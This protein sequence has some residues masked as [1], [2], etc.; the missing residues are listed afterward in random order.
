VHSVADTQVCSNIAV[1]DRPPCRA[2]VHAKLT[3][4]RSSTYSLAAALLWLRHEYARS[5]RWWGEGKGK[6]THA[7]CTLTE[8]YSSPTD[9]R[10]TSSMICAS[11]TRLIPFSGRADRR[12][13]V[14][15]QPRNVKFLSLCQSSSWGA[16]RRWAWV[17]SWHIYFTVK[18][19]SQLLNMKLCRTQRCPASCE[20]DK[21]YLSLPVIE[22]RFSSRRLCSLDT[23]SDSASNQRPVEQKSE[24]LPTK[25]T[26]PAT[27]D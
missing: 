10:P 19:R 9:I 8:D 1:F 16:Q 17:A 18:K 3:P 12:I 20:E 23:F 14:F 4:A 5:L 21:N 11:S 22:L 15:G 2:E 25:S 26:C 27:L 6:F 7:Q 24:T 13:D